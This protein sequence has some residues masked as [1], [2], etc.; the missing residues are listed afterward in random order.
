MR[1]ITI[2]ILVIVLS[3]SGGQAQTPTP[4]APAKPVLN[5]TKLA[6]DF[7]DRLNTLDDWRLSM[8]GK[9]VGVD[10]IV[11]G[12]MAPFAPDVL[13]ELPPDD[14]EQIGPLELNGAAQLRKWVEK[15]ARS[16]VELGFL[17]GRQT[18]NAVEGELMVFSKP[19][20]WGGL[21]IAFQVIAPYS[22]RENRERFM[23]VGA[24]FLQYDEDGKIHRFRLYL[25]EKS[26]VD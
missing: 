17:L 26:P 2:S 14:E 5:P 7:V 13:A 9:E 23:E 21:G 11:D 1:W 15:I 25:S 20:P 12:F 18:Q 22:L 19:L 6:T 16:R 4:P 8:D 3:A 10:K 24:V